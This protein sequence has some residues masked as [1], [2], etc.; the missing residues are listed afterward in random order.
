MPWRLI[1]SS[2]DGDIDFALN[3]PTVI[4][5]GRDVD[6][7]IHLGQR[8]VSRL[9]A[10]MHWA[11][12]S[13]IDRGHW[14]VRDCGSTS[15]SFLNGVKLTP[16][17]EVRLYHSDTLEIRP[18]RFQV[19]GPS[20]DQTIAEVCQTLADDADSGEQ[21]V[22]LGEQSPKDLAQ[23]M[24][25]RLLAAS[26]D[27]AKAPDEL[28][29]GQAAI[30]AL[31]S[32]TGF[33]NV[34]FLRPGS[35]AR[36]IEVVAEVGEISG[37]RGEVQVSRSLLKRSRNGIYVHRG[38]GAGSGTLGASLESL[39][40]RQAISVPVEAGTNFFGW[41]YLDNR[42][43]GTSELHE[44][45]AAGFASAVARLTGLSLANIARGKMQQRFDL[46]SQQMFGGTMRA[47]IRA[48]DA[49]DPYTRGHSDRVSEF[50]VLLAR[51]AALSD[52][53]IEQARVCGL[54]HDIGKI[55]VPEEILRKPTHLEAHEFDRIRQHPEIGHAILRDIPQMR[56]LLPGVM[57][58][59]ERWDGSGYPH[60]LKGESISMLG[61][62][63]C[64]ADC[65]DAMTSARFYRPARSIAEVRS[66]IE[67]C[68]GTHF[69][70]ELGRVFLS[71]RDSELA[72]RISTAITPL[73]L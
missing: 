4:T 65:F 25:V 5:I 57:Q 11:P 37:S 60:N 28:S 52:E 71:I 6:C 24:L 22:A 72:S 59:H 19:E 46:E 36:M 1:G 61:R 41:L 56:D 16:H 44:L 54:V 70:P 9:H 7:T 30:E 31:A 18:W 73:G 50:A 23:G 27:I 14:R 33:A 32:A 42:S 62:L 66:E 38:G 67:R 8:Q 45:E 34:A 20:S 13:G 2:V 53:H 51:A 63:L 15:G 55:G 21:F 58:H 40:I 39:S 43:G 48:I 47:L 64:I 29:V 10:E 26:E 69:D 3:P 68:L 12:E 17:R 35:D 49:K